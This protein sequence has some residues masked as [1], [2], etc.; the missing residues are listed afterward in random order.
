MAK[1]IRIAR[2]C[3]LMAFLLTISPQRFSTS[4]LEISQKYPRANA[5]RPAIGLPILFE[6]NV[7]QSDPRVRFLSHA[8][9]AT[10]FVTDDGAELVFAP[11][12]A[13][14][15]KRIPQRQKPS[16][17]SALRMRLSGEMAESWTEARWPLTTRVNY[18]IGHDPHRW[19]RNVP[20]FREVVQREVW[21]G[22][23]VVYRGNRGEL[24]CDFDVSPGADL[25][26]V[27]LEFD[28]ASSAFVATAGDLLL[29]VGRRQVRSALPT[30]YTKDASGKRRELAA[31][32]VINSQ[33]WGSG[34][35]ET[36]AGALVACNSDIG[37]ALMYH[38]ACVKESF[39]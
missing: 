33:G 19:H 10:F 13:T 4:K 9:G 21:R 25:S 22:I 23:D 16:N 28:G 24:E 11:R 38:E 1:E 34:N 18:F 5:S 35:P 39:A 29:E 12:S 17:L 31:R 37:I 36:L 8:S 27:R 26:Q 3:L 7:G 15:Q 2:F 20:T 32:Y 14:H 30:V 6:R